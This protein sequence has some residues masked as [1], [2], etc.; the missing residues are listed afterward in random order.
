MA[1]FNVT[2]PA[3]R[4]SRP[5]SLG[6]DK[7]GQVMT[8]REG[9]REDRQMPPEADRR[10]DAPA[11]NIALDGD[12]LQGRVEEG[13]YRCRIPRSTLKGLMRRSDAA[14]LANFCPWVLLLV[15]SGGLA[16]LSWGSWWS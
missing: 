1:N 3:A 7:G 9:Q 15:A 6:P 11:K 13:W 14:G 12:G 4:I 10:S 2:A 5:T 8:A 16:Y